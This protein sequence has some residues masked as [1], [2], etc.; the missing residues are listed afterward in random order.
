MTGVDAFGV[1]VRTATTARSRGSSRTKIW[2]AGVRASPL[3][4]LLAQASGA[5][6]D[7]AGR[8]VVREDCTLPGHPEVFA[9][10]DMM[11]LHD[12]P[13]VAEVAMQSGIHAANT[14]KRRLRG[15]KAAPFTYRDLGS[16]ATIS[17]FHAVVSFK[18]IRLSGF[19]G[20]LMWLVV[21]ITFL[22][23]FRDRLS[24]A[25]HWMNDVP[26]RA[27][28][29]S[30]ITLRQVIGRVALADAGG[31]DLTGGHGATPEQHDDPVRSRRLELHVTQQPDKGRAV[32]TDA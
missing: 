16:M 21:H 17:R 27:A 31:D 8:I 23:G 14:I 18:G 20:W 24:A 32:L 26:G 9:I 12:L 4:G 7:R 1:D 6:C 13:G 25:F 15:K 28:A 11:A 3:A 2:A 10:G 5:T 30:T 22:T 19:L 29:P